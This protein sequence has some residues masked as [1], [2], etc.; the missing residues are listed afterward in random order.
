MKWL[1][2]SLQNISKKMN[3]TQISAKQFRTHLTVLQS[4]DLTKIKRLIGELRIQGDARYIA[5]LV[6]VLNNSAHDEIKE[7]IFGMLLDLKDEGALD[8]L[9]SCIRDERYI[10]IRPQLLSVLWQSNLDASEYLN[11]LIQMAVEFDYLECIEIMTILDTFE[12]GFSEDELMDSIYSL[13]EAIE[14]EHS[15]KTELLIE[16][17]S[18]VNNLTVV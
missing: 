9:F 4:D 12:D 2:V 7:V 18:I 16:I 1:C 17:K 15:N 6:D 14:E 13:D 11:E 5:P 10:D 3:T 8:P